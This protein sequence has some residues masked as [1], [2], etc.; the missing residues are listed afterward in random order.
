MDVFE[1][2]GLFFDVLGF[3]DLLQFLA[4]LGGFPQFTDAFL[5]VL[6][7]VGPGP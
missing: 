7:Q 3:G 5:F 1:R 2:L 6:L 4:L